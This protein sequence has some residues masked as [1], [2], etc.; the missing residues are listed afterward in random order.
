MVEAR[1]SGQ[2]AARVEGN[3]INVISDAERK[4]RPPSCSGRGSRANVSVLGLSYGA[5]TLGSASRSG[6]RWSPA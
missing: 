2:T 6:R 4:G 5:F 3:G 1:K